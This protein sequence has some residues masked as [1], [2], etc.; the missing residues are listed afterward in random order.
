VSHTKNLFSPRC[1]PRPGHE[2]PPRK[3]SLTPHQRLLGVFSKLKGVAAASSD[4][5]TQ[6]EL[7]EAARQL[8]QEICN[9]HIFATDAFVTKNTEL[10]AALAQEIR[11]ECQEL[12]EYIVAAKRFNLEVNSRSKDRVISFGEKLSCRFM[13]ALLKDRVWTKPSPSI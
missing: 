7:V 13:A 6:N 1:K 2:K 3:G 8:V 11:D 12:A 5:E 9:D 10:K 4:E